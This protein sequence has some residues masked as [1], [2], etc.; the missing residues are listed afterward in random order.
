[1]R[2]S[3]TT[4]NDC[5]T[6]QLTHGREAYIDANDLPL[7]SGYRWIHVKG[8]NDHLHYAI[9]TFGPRRQRTHIRMHRLILGLGRGTPNTNVDHI[10]GNGLNNTRA[11]LRVCTTYQNSLN[12]GPQKNNSTGFKGVAPDPYGGWQARISVNRKQIHL[13]HR[14]PTPEDAARAY[15][16]AARKLHGEFAWLNFP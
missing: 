11:N 12:A 16:D 9:T 2:S 13:G 4:P 7:I 3:F 15:D 5:I 10:D 8:A 1:V 14:F 6:I